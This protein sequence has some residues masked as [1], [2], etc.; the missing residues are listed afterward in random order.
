MAPVHC[1]L[2]GLQGT[3]LGLQLCPPLP[4]TLF[5]PQ[6]RRQPIF[7]ILR[8]REVSRLSLG[9]TATVCMEPCVTGSWSDKQKVM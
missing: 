5:A 4:G 1:W 8:L 7:Q 3:G 2:W 6:A 9:H